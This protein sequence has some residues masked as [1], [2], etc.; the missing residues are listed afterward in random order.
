MCAIDSVSAIYMVTSP[1]QSLHLPMPPVST[2]SHNMSMNSHMHILRTKFTENMNVHNMNCQTLQTKL[3]SLSVTGLNPVIDRIIAPQVCMYSSV[4][5]S[6]A[7]YSYL[8]AS[9]GTFPRSG[10]R[11][12]NLLD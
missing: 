11:Q 8:L 4:K 1:T 2:Y 10:I 7:L 6:F 3:I 12:K 5:H 9:F